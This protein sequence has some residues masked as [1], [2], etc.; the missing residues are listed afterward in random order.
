[1]TTLGKDAPLRA[2]HLPADSNSAIDESQSVSVERLEAVGWKISSVPGGQDETEQ[3]A[4][5]LAEE[6]GFPVAQEGCKVPFHLDL[7]K[8]AAKL[9]PEMVGLVSQAAEAQNSDICLANEAIVAVTGGS[10]SLDVED[11]TTAVWVRFHLDAG[12]I[13]CVPSGGRYR[14]DFHEENKGATGIAYFKETIS[15]H[16]LLMKDEIDNHPARHTY[17]STRQT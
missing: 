9:A 11:V 3:A 2:Y 16:G 10:L 4:Q 1:M 5:K 13:F 15:N 12:T 7:E 6:L 8:H 14:I 17:L